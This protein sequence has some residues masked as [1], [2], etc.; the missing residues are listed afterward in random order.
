MAFNWFG[1][2]SETT[3]ILPALFN[4]SL[5]EG[6]FVDI[7][8]KAIY[9][10][11]LTDVVERTNGLSDDQSNTFWDSCLK[12]DNSEG[13]ITM[14]S[15]GMADKKDMFLVYDKSLKL[16][17]R[18]TQSEQSQ[19]REDYKQKAKSDVGIY[20]SFNRFTKTD[21]LKIYS[22]LEYCT[23]TALN[24]GMNISTALQVAISELRAGVGL[25]DA[26]IAKAQAKEMADALSDGKS[27]L[28]DVK[29]QIR[30]ALPDL[31]S[32]EKAMQF[33]NERRSFYLGLPASYVM[34]EQTGGLGTTGEND[35]KAI[36]RG[37][38]NY[39]HS[40]IKPVLQALFGVKTSYKSQDFRQI[41][42]ALEA[43]KTF[44]L[45][46]DDYVGPVSKK[47]IVSSLLDLDEDDLR[48][49]EKAIEK[50]K[51]EEPK[52]P[53]NNVPNAN[54]NVPPQNNSGQ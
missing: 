9:S 14:L 4:L 44:D 15:E 21:M 26:E 52:V 1:K 25:A 47:K 5:E 41:S 19:I 45:I 13:L 16:L 37:L 51:K 8:V 35:T 36:E 6:K 50:Q 3:S 24:K 29:D 7:D 53:E 2:T 54:P 20:V 49:D 34:G 22:A 31:T 40:I 17:R 43:L 18:A 27:I 39:Y 38:K 32:I 33:L 46:S 11:I 28:L 10:K 48:E 12:S 30:T 42:Q 23:I